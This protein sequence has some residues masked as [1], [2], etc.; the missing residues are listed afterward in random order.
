MTAMSDN[1]TPPNPINS[2]AE[3]AREAVNTVGSAA[4][5]LVG[6]ASEAASGALDSARDTA[7]NAVDTAQ[8]G[9][10]TGLGYA[11]KTVAEIGD[12]AARNVKSHPA[13]TALIAA[14][15]V[16]AAFVVG[17]ITSRRA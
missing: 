6:K 8:Q 5:D 14:G 16:I 9:V 2:A 1:Y 15:V 4:S 12:K 13:R 7:N 11:V 10:S 17:V 3:H